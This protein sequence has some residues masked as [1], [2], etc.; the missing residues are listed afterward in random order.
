VLQS[1]LFGRLPAHEPVTVDRGYDKLTHFVVGIFG[2][3][4][5]CPTR[6]KLSVQPIDVID[7]QIAKPIVRTKRARVDV[8]RTLAQ[9]YANAI[10]LDQ[11]P[12]R[13]ILPTDPEAKEVAEILSALVDIRNSEHEGPRGHF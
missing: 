10:P 8:S 9:H 12:I 2:R 6:S 1:G 13:R 7:F 5:E 3:R 11:S 4:A